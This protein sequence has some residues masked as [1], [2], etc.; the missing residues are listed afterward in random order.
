MPASMP[1]QWKPDQKTHL[2]IGTADLNRTVVAVGN[3]FCYGKAKAIVMAV[4]ACLIS[5]V[6]TVKN[7]FL[8]FRRDL[9]AD[10]GYCKKGVSSF[11]QQA[12]RHRL[13]G[14][15]VADRIV[16][17]NGN[18]LF[19]LYIVSNQAHGIVQTGLQPD[20]M[21]KGHCLK[22]EHLPK[23]QMAQVDLRH[24]R[25][26]SFG[27]GKIQKLGNETGHPSVFI[28]NVSKPGI[29]LKLPGK[30]FD[31]GSDHCHRRFKFVA[32]VRNKLF[33]APVAFLQRR[34]DTSCQIPREQEQR[35]QRHAS[36]HQRIRIPHRV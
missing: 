32:G 36:K 5:T 23:H 22:G 8:L 13:T 25:R 1:L 10:V 35:H 7:V 3:G 19:E 6:K 2:A 26:D 20:T 34:D 21:L 9:R 15:A 33:L 12:D 29:V 24:Y 28:S 16:N 11:L 18:K 27:A 30:Q 14:R 31:I 4:A 17:K